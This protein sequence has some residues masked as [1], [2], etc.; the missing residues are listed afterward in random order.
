M[1]K[2]PSRA[3]GERGSATKVRTRARRSITA[4]ERREVVRRSSKETSISR[5]TSA[6]SKPRRLVGTRTA[7]VQSGRPRAK[8]RARR[9]TYSSSSS[10]P[11]KERRAMAL[12][13]SS[14]FGCGSPA[15]DRS[16]RWRRKASSRTSRTGYSRQVQATRPL[17]SSMIRGEQRPETDI[18]MVRTSPRSRKRRRNRGSA[19]VKVLVI[20]W[21][22]SPTRIQC[23]ER[24]VSLPRS[25]SWRGTLSW[26][27]SSSTTGQRPARRSATSSWEARRST[28]RRTMSL[29]SM[30]PQLS[31][32]S[33]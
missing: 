12:S 22:G 26:A 3:A 32:R 33:W 11:S 16:M 23:P 31:T 18:S 9:A 7:R 30:P 25:S 2:T 17:A 15:P 1:R 13:P 20:D 14:G 10:R 24:A 6:I 4:R 28:A 29:K 8:P 19:E 21:F 5:R 27:S